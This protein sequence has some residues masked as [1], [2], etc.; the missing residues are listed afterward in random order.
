MYHSI[1]SPNANLQAAAA[2]A[3]TDLL[4]ELGKD[5]MK[6]GDNYR[7]AKWLEKAH[8]V[9]TCQEADQL[10]TDSDDLK[11]SILHYLGK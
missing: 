6:R 1:M 7:A 4:F 5:L 8:S 2:E 11:L 3:L 10:S 9:L